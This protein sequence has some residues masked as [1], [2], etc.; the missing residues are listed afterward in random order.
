MNFPEGKE[1]EQL[2]YDQWVDPDSAW[3]ELKRLADEYQSQGHEVVLVGEQF[4]K[5]PGVVH[6]DFT[7]KYINRDVENNIFDYEIVWQIPAAAKNLVKYSA[8]AADGRDGLRRF[9]WYITGKQ[10]AN[11]AT[12][13]AIVYAVEK[14]KHKATILLGWPRKD[15]H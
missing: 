9:G 11:D 6:P 8:K 15:D 5:R 2:Y 7:A 14:L 12:R 13:H 3:R 4:D 1:A 10:H